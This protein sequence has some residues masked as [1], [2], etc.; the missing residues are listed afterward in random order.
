MDVRNKTGIVNSSPSNEP[1]MST[2]ILHPKTGLLSYNIMLPN[3]SA[4][5]KF[6]HN[7]YS[8]FEFPIN[9]IT[10]LWSYSFENMIK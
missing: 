2:G 4:F 9:E 3:D 8:Q 7:V 5:R 10:I 1:G 6:S